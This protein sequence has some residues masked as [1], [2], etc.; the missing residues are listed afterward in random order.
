MNKFR[1]IPLA[2]AVVLLAMTGGYFAGRRGRTTAGPDTAATA[3]AAKRKVLYWTDPMIPNFRSAR[4]GKSPMGMQMLPVYADDSDTDA[5]SDVR[6]TADMVNNLGVR[7]AEVE[8]GSLSPR[9][10]SVGYVGYDE[11]TITSL[12]TRAD[13]WV[14]KLGVKSAGDSVRA[15]QMLYELFS[16]KLATAEREYLVALAS[17]SPSLIAA[18]RERMQALGFSGAQVA[19]LARTRKIGDRVARYAAT[20]GVVMSLGVSE[21]AYV[22]PATQIMK[23]AD[24]RTVWVLAEVDESAA[25]LLHTGQKADA[26]FDAFPG[27]HWQGVVDYVYPDI[28]SAT[29]TVK[30]RLR[31]ANPGLRLQPNMYAHVGIEAAPRRDVV[32]IPEL[33]L[34]RT[35]NSQ[36]VIVALG[37]G[38]FDVCPVQAGFSSGD[39]VEILKGLRAGQRVVTSAQFMLDSEAN[40]D[41]AALR[42]GSG[43]PGCAEAP[44]TAHRGLPGKA[45]P[46]GRER[47]KMSMPSTHGKERQA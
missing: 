47:P 43:R 5:A 25:A 8:Q 22:V 33:A 20:A 13:G 3:P 28:S 35:G 12:N 10:E 21:G 41:A 19:Q 16:P 44:D 18:S 45:G 15:G 24:L 46:A 31:F 6:I 27:R 40:V 14:E 7:T 26:V 38:R 34:I 1:W 4:P 30:A 32:Q 29:R 36:R 42:L 39:K 11:D 17:G 37:D 2:A 9:L 23:L